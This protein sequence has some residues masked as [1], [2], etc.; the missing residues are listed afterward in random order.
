MRQSCATCVFSNI[1]RVPSGNKDQKEGPCLP[2]L[3]LHFVLGFNKEKFLP[4]TDSCK[5]NIR[6]ES[7]TP[8]TYFLLSFVLLSR[9]LLPKKF[10][11]DEVL[12][13][14]PSFFVWAPLPRFFYKI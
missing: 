8:Y 4:S 14:G 6:E 10:F 1:K 7:N 13:G 2:N 3:Q 12:N 9:L 5:A 11:D